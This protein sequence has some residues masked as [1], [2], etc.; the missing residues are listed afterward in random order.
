MSP[1]NKTYNYFLFSETR[2]QDNYYIFRR[3]IFGEEIITM[4]FPHTF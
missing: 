2:F 4:N 3:A 1:E